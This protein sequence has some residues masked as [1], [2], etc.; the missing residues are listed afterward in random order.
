[1]KM[2]KIIE[3][4]KKDKFLLVALVFIIVGLVFTLLGIVK[5]YTLKT[6]KINDN[7]QVWGYTW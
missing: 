7:Y 5:A 1:M 2:K 3:L 4:I 6:V